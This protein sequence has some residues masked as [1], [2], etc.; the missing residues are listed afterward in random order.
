MGNFQKKKKC[1]TERKRMWTVRE[2][3]SRSP[4]DEPRIG[5]TRQ[6]PFRLPLDQ[7]RARV[8]HIWWVDARGTFQKSRREGARPAGAATFGPAVSNTPHDPRQTNHASATHARHLFVSL[9]TRRVRGYAVHGGLELGALFK[10]RE[11]RAS[12]LPAPANFWACRSHE[13][14]DTHQT[15]HTSDYH[16]GHFFLHVLTRRIRGYAC[17]AEMMRF[18]IFRFS[19]RGSQG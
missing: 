19:S 3:T 1:R 13:P 11:A 12:S 6:A 2:H 14:P 18:G 4:S 16:G 17:L 5:H 7:A 9:L 10:T 8:C 15:N